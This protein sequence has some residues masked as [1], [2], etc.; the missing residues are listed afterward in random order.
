ME[1]TGYSRIT[2]NFI[3]SPQ[4]GAICCNAQTMGTVGMP[5]QRYQYVRSCC[6]VSVD[7]IRRDQDLL[8]RRRADLRKY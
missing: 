3:P 1:F 8:M 6:N 5:P 7:N 2:G 4:T